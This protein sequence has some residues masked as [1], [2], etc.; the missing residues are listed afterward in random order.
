M[1]KSALL[2][3]VL[4]VF[5]LSRQIQAQY[6]VKSPYLD[7]PDKAIAY[8]DSC[9]RFWL[10][11]WDG[12]R[13][14]F[15]SSIDRYGN[16]VWSTNKNMLSQSR[17]AYGLTRAFMLTGDTTYLHLAEEALDFMYQHAWDKIYG[18]WFQDLDINGDAPNPYDSKTAFYQHYALLGISAYYEASGDSTAWS[19]LMKGYD[20]LEKFFW[21]ARP[22]F[23]GYYDATDFDGSNPRNKSFNATV[24]A[25]TTHLLYLNLMTED[26]AYRLRLQEM[27]R[28]RIRHLIAGMPWQAIGFVEKYDSDWNWDN[29]ETMTIMGHVLK[30]GWCLARLYQLEPDSSAYL[31]AAQEL[32]RHV[33]QKG[34]DHEFGGPYKDYDRT[35]GQMLMWGNPDTCKAWWQMEQAVVAGLQLFDL[36]KD[37]LYLQMADETV[38]FFMK[39]FVDHQYGEVYADRTRYGGFAWSENKTDGYHAIEL[40]YYLYLYGNLFL[41]RKPVTLH[42]RFAPS[43]ASRNVLLTPLAIS[44]NTLRIQQVLLDGQVYASYDLDNRV[45]SLPAGIGGRFEV[46]YQR[47]DPTFVADRRRKTLPESIEL[48]QNYPNPFNPSTTI[49]Y[50]LLKPAHIRLLIYDVLGRHIRTLSDTR[51]Q[52]GHFQTSWDGTDD[53]KVPVAAGVYFCRLEAGDPSTGSWQ[54]FVKAIKLALV[55]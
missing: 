1:R 40:G 4:S 54:G 2:F 41:T 5:Q 15:F 14:G 26:P 55:R 36:T 32:V 30:A 24:D 33:W 38:D 9:A 49:A 22:A 27:A 43:S 11:T 48:Y 47:I 16:A 12:S 10:N 34:Y 18:G 44:D 39:Y 42:Y 6:A 37:S 19:W 28:E 50:D 21:D 20:H 35:T 46:T 53:Q 17:N 51:Q 7:E 29:S 31:M 13:G 25:I 52:V 45:L 23:S 3:L 8:V